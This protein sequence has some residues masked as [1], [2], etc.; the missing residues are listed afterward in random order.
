MAAAT[1]EEEK[2]AIAPEL[3]PAFSG[4]IAQQFHD[5]ATAHDIADYGMGAAYMY[6]DALRHADAAQLKTVA[7]YLA[8]NTYLLYDILPRIQHMV[9]HATEARAAALRPDDVEEL[10]DFLE[11]CAAL[12]RE[13][14]LPAEMAAAATARMHEWWLKAHEH[15]IWVYVQHDVAKRAARRV[16]DAVMHKDLLP[17]IEGRA[18]E[19]ATTRAD[20]YVVVCDT[21]DVRACVRSAELKSVQ[22]RLVVVVR[23]GEP[24]EAMQAAAALGGGMPVA[25]VWLEGRAQRSS[26]LADIN[27]DFIR[28]CLAK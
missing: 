17:A 3:A 16:A 13:P 6:Y 22:P 20:V 18:Y 11:Q 5:L 27:R 15:S 12:N 23:S 8:N 24:R 4:Q 19:M 26:V 7:T 10:S 1:A 25:T 21:L 9:A 2:S 14:V 28:R